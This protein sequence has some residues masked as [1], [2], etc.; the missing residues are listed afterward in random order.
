VAGQD[1]IVNAAGGGVVTRE[2]NI[3]K[4]K[5]NGILV[6]L[7]ASVDT[8]AGRIGEDSQRPLLVGRT[9]QEDM[10]I[11]LNERKPL[12]QKVADLVV[13]TE[14][15]TPEEAADLVINLLTTSNRR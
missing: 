8:L 11:T 14:K 4:L 5:E 6:W 3:T 7:T 1:S 15:K 2:K 9:L 12:Y 13:D 10:E